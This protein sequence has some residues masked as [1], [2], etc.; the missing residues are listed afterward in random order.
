MKLRIIKKNNKL[1]DS[2]YKYHEYFQNSRKLILVLA[3]EYE[4]KRTVF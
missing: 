4:Y 1:L 3:N 2:V